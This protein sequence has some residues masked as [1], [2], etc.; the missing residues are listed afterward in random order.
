MVAWAIENCKGCFANV[1]GVCS[2]LT[3]VEPNC[4]FYKTK[5]QYKKDLEDYPY[6]P[7]CCKDRK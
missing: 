3:K 4:N 1:K 7:G 5:E 6:N 2:C